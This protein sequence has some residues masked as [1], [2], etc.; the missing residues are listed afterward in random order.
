MFSFTTLNLLF[1]FSWVG[2]TNPLVSAH[3]ALVFLSLFTLSLI[4]NIN[5]NNVSNY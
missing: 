2:A 5:R 4:L 1:L 3:L